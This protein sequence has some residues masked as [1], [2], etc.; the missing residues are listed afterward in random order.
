MSLPKR[1]NKYLIVV[2]KS[3]N[4][5]F[6]V[7]DRPVQTGEQINVSGPQS[8]TCRGCGHV[9]SYDP[10]EMQTVQIG[11]RPGRE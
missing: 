3:C 1:G 7:L 5:G 4:K 8:L 11:P 10:S 2:C 9:A 6:R